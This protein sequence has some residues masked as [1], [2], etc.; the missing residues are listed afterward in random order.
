MS[1]RW[2]SVEDVGQGGY[3]GAVDDDRNPEMSPC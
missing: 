2:E 3:I 1:D